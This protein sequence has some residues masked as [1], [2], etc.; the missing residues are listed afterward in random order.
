VLI[1]NIDCIDGAGNLAEKFADL[2]GFVI[3]ANG[4]GLNFDCYVKAP[5]N[6][7]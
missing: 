5:K 2:K 6:F 7:K 1:K 4:C 3:H